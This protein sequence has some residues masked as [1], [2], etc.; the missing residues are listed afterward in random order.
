MSTQVKVDLVGALI[1]RGKELNDQQTKEVI[2]GLL[3]T[4]RL[5]LNPQIAIQLVKLE[6]PKPK[7]EDVAQDTGAITGTTENLA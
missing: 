5:A 1:E 6:E 3:I 2:D 4:H 7:F